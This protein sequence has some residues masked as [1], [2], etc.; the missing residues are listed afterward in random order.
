MST[1]EL[2]KKIIEKINLIE[3][4]DLLKETS[5]LIDIELEVN[6]QPYILNEKMINAVSHAKEQFDSGEFLSHN[7]ANKE[8]DK[9]F[10]K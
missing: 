8:I 10:E 5:R 3:N 4:E 1:I 9:W 2:K 7:K 6:E